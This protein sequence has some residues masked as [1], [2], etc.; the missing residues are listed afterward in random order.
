MPTVV[1]KDASEE[2]V[3]IA[4]PKKTEP[5]PMSKRPEPPLSKGTLVAQ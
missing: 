5:T 4:V 3:P 1:K 2:K